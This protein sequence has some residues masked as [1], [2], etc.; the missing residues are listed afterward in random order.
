MMMMLTQGRIKHAHEMPFKVQGNQY[1]Q[2]EAQVQ[3]TLEQL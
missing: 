2:A 1:T 3:G